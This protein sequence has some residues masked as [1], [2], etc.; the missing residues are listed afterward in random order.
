MQFLDYQGV[1]P[2][3][4]TA[5]LNNQPF[6]QG[7]VPQAS[8]QA[9]QQQPATPAPL[10]E[11][12]MFNGQAL[13][14]RQALEIY[15]QAMQPGYLDAVSPQY[16]SQFE[17]LIEA[18]TPSFG[19]GVP[20]MQQY[21]SGGGRGGGPM[22]SGYNAVAG[23]DFG[24]GD[25]MTGMSMIG[26]PIGMASGLAFGKSPLGA[27]AEALGFGDAMGGNGGIAGSSD[28]TGHGAG[29]VGSDGMP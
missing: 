22:G 29:E 4:Y 12:Y 19:V 7:G 24:F 16:R 13:P 23:P 27:L 21:F 9:P 3:A 10:Q 1:D 14:Q 25:V 26:G 2:Q 20:Q 8:T 11:T 18:I 15:A 5:S 6:V 17:Q 28:G